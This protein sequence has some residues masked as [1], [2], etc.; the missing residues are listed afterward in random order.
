[1]KLEPGG[2]L[3]V[4]LITGDFDM[5]GI[6]TVTH[7]EDKRVWG[8]GH[9]FMSMG[10]C[11]FPLM[12]GYVVTV[13]PRQTVSFKMGSPLKT[14]GVINADVSTCIAGWL[15]KVPDMMPMSMT[16]RREPGGETHRYNV[17]IVRQ[18]QLL[19]SLVYAALT[20]SIDMHGDLPDEITIGFRCRIEI[21][22]KPAVEIKDTYAGLS[23]AGGRAPGTLYSQVSAIVGQIV[24][25]P[26]E[27]V[28]IKKIDCETEILPG[29]TSAEIEG[30]ELGADTYSPGDTLTGS[31]Y[32]RP[33]KGT[34]QKLAVSLKLPADLPDGSYQVGV[35]DEVSSARADLRGQ[36]QLLNPQTIDQ[37]LDGIRR[38]TAA[39]RT[40]LAVRLTLPPAGVAIDG[41]A[42]P[43]LPPSAVQMFGQTRRTAVQAVTPSVVQTR[44]TSWVV[45]GGESARFTVSR[46]KRSAA[47]VE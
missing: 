47:A 24:S 35:G 16:V 33:Y 22:G 18:K 2:A 4:A 29:R 8:W 19:P 26:F 32:V 14:V 28:R 44:M 17:Q 21:E 20:N 7:V 1:V 13:Y 39:K 6:G 12:T 38:L 40:N 36:P 30:F 25:N 46:T 3:S 27:P 42:L 11:E 45:L 23:Y 9:P 37:L 34:V 5:S 41:R 31:V 10:G 43:N 15:D